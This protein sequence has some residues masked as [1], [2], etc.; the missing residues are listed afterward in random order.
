MLTED[1]G[2]GSADFAKTICGYFARDMLGQMSHLHLRLAIEKGVEDPST[3]RAAYLCSV[4]VDFA[5]HGRC[6]KVEAM[7]DLKKTI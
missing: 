1:V 3:E 6:I 5:K 2:G 4:Q 7:E